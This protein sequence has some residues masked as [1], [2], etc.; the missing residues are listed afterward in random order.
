MLTWEHIEKMIAHQQFIREKAE[1]EY[2]EAKN[3]VPKDLWH[4]Y[5]AFANS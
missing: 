2:K 3:S 1:I 5:S 4:T